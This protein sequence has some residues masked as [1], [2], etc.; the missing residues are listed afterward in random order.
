MIVN[1]GD[2]LNHRL[3]VVS[4]DVFH[5]AATEVPTMDEIRQ[6]LVDAFGS[7]LDAHSPVWI[8]RFG[9][10][11]RIA[12]SFRAGRV[13]LAGDAAHQ[14]FPAGGQ[15]MNVG[16]QDATN[17]AWKLAIASQLESGNTITHNPAIERILDS[18]NRERL[19][20]ATA[21]TENVQAQLACFLA[22]SKHA[23]AL[24]S[25][26]AEALTI[27]PLNALWAQ[28]MSGFGEPRA[29]YSTDAP[30]D[31]ARLVGTVFTHLR[32]GSAGGDVLQ[33][34]ASDR[35]TLL[36][37]EDIGDLDGQAELKAEVARWTRVNLLASQTSSSDSRWDDV[38]AVLIRPDLRI[39][40]SC[41][42]TDRGLKAK[43]SL[44][45][46]LQYWLG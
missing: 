1:T 4:K 45:A 40:W 28:R 20:V 38:Y 21:V 6:H 5:K 37:R 44:T 18:Y 31:K 42:K 25:V 35:F 22:D 39:A 10:A 24:R 12:S 29:P 7:D 8:S 17:L 26:M 41:Q 19:S 32:V 9:N 11:S 33:K 15:G 34:L 43:L 2:G 13:F 36:L 30:Q 27:P 23:Q 3:A 46:V 16:L 14:F